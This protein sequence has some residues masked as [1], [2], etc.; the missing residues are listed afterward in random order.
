MQI[1]HSARLMSV[2]IYLVMHV[3]VIR[4]PLWSHTTVIRRHILFYC[5]TFFSKEA[6]L[7]HT[8]A[9]WLL[10]SDSQFYIYTEI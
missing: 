9:C 2:V 8:K 7:K 6:F 1:Q 3:I 5:L 4:K 10:K